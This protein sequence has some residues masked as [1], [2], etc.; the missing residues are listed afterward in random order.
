MTITIDSGSPVSILTRSL[1]PG[2]LSASEERLC[3]YGGSV[4]NMLGTQCVRVSSH[5]QNIC[6]NVY[7]VPH[8]GALMG[9]DL[10]EVFNV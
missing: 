7:V 2:D 1:V 8:G 9:L 4:L 5:G 3:A 6:V 10:T